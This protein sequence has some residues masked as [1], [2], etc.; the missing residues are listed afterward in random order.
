MATNIYLEPTTHDFTLK[1]RNLRFTATPTEYFSQKIENTLKLNF[2]EYF[3]D[4]GRG[5][6]YWGPKGKVMNKDFDLNEIR[7][8]MITEILNIPSVNS[9]QSLDLT[10]NH[11]TRTLTAQLRVM[12]DSAALITTEINI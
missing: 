4:R 9:V 2:G 3:L 12:T 6:P 11:G 10:F 1:D 7:S 5:F 8:L